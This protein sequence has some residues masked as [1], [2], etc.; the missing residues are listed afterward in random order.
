MQSQASGQAAH[1]ADKLNGAGTAFLPSVICAHSLDIHLTFSSSRYSSSL[2]QNLDWKSSISAWIHSLT[3]ATSCDHPMQCKSATRCHLCT[4]NAEPSAP[5]ITLMPSLSKSA[6]FAHRFCASSRQS[7]AP[8]G[9]QYSVD[10][11]NWPGGGRGRGRKGTKAMKGSR[12]ATHRSLACARPSRALGLQPTIV[13]RVSTSQ[14]SSSI[15]P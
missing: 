14:L 1:V 3:T 6:F 8:I 12:H 5:L 13:M 11:N 2:G 4:D 10:F 9:T 7:T 15:E